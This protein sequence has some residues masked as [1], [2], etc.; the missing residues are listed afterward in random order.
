MRVYWWRNMFE[1]E[2]G[3][4]LFENEICLRMKWRNMF[5]NE[6]IC[7]RTDGAIDTKQKTGNDCRILTSTKSLKKRF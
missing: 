1:N 7:L 6:E 5:E 2:D 3:I 4:Q